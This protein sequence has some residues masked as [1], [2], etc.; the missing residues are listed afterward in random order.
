M[1]IN[2]VCQQSWMIGEFDMD[3]GVFRHSS[4]PAVAIFCLISIAEKNADDIT[5]ARLNL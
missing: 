2:T 4:L 1:I 3:K 5:D